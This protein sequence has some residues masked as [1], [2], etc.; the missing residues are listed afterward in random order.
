MPF[1]N[2]EES[3][4]KDKSLK[5]RH[6]GLAGLMTV[7]I[8]YGVGVQSEKS[9][10]ETIQDIATQEISKMQGQIFVL[11]EERERDFVRKTELNQTM[12][13]IDQKLDRVDDNMSAVRDEMAQ[14]KGY[15]KG[16]RKPNSLSSLEEEEETPNYERKVSRR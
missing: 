10:K 3:T 7:L 8:Q 16:Q 4:P 9:T 5:P 15:I 2:H 14:I 12:T 1:E 6:L 13:R 11:R